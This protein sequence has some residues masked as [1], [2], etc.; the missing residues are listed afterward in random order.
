MVQGESTNSVRG[1]LDNT[2]LVQANVIRGDV[3]L[4]TPE[5][6]VRSAA[7]GAR[8]VPALGT[9]YRAMASLAGCA[10]LLGLATG[11]DPMAQLGAMCQ[12]LG[13]PSDWTSTA[14][15]WIQIRVVGLGWAGLLLLLVGV[16]TLPAPHRLGGDLGEVL[17]WRGPSTALLGAVLMLQCHTAPSAWATVAGNIGAVAWIRGRAAAHVGYDSMGQILMVAVMAPMLAAGFL[18]LYCVAALLGRDDVK[19]LAD[20][21]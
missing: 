11:R 12:W 9:W 6:L 5:R 7:R 10:A 21:A 4:G 2:R 15:H 17:R 13:L 8:A 20:Q 18:P 19:G 3:W 16:M 14:A 1:R